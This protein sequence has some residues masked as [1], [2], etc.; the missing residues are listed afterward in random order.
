VLATIETLG[1]RKLLLLQKML[2]LEIIIQTN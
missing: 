2:R 1:I